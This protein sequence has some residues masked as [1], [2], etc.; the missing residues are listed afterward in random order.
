MSISN[1]VAKPFTVALSTDA[2]GHDS[3]FVNDAQIGEFARPCG[4]VV[5]VTYT[6]NASTPFDPTFNIVITTETSG[7][8]ILG[9]TTGVGPWYP[10]TKLLDGQSGAPDLP[11]SAD[12]DGN[13]T[14]Q[15]VPVYVHGERIRVAVN[16]G[17]SLKSGTITVFVR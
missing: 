14:Y 16:N 17:G 12:A 11:L 8:T 4:E 13:T 10:R 5:K 2:S 6:P 3:D 7:E 15:T 1:A 9:S